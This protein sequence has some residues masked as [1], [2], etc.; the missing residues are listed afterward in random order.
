MQFKMRNYHIQKT[1]CFQ[2]LVGCIYVLLPNPTQLEPFSFCHT[3]YAPNRTHFASLSWGWSHRIAAY[4]QLYKQAFN[5]VQISW[6]FSVSILLLNHLTTVKFRHKLKFTRVF[7]LSLCSPISL[8]DCIL[9]GFKFCQRTLAYYNYHPKYLVPE[10]LRTN[11]RKFDYNRLTLKFL[12]LQ[13]LVSDV[14]HISEK[15][16]SR[17]LKA[18]TA[19]IYEVG[20]WYDSIRISPHWKP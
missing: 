5:K 20:V 18:S 6:K 15:N 12:H 2:R 17:P 16:C 14:V 11:I 19:Q 13:W 7:A 1:Q 4:Q 3:F 8:C 9:T 10:V